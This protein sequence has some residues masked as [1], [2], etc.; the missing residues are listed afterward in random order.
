[1]SLPIAPRV[2]LCLGLLAAAACGSLPEDEPAPTP[3]DGDGP[4]APALSSDF[5]CVA[6][7]RRVGGLY[8]KNVLGLTEQAVAVAESDGDWHF[9]VGTIIQGQPNEA[10]LKRGPGFSPETGDWEYITLDN[11]GTR[12]VITAR[13]TTDVQGV[14]QTC[15]ACHAPAGDQWDYICQD[16]HGCEPIPASPVLFETLRS[17]DARCAQ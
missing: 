2:L 16:D 17:S 15:A 4:D 13:G 12:T 14:G 10:M 1:M 8:L 7:Y 6:D 5:G 9:P 11:D 3:Y